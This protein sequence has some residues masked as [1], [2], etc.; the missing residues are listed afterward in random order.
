MVAEPAA[1]PIV[2]VGRRKMA[3]PAIRLRG[4]PVRVVT[5]KCRRHTVGWSTDMAYAAVGIDPQGQM[6]VVAVPIQRIAPGR[7]VTHWLFRAVARVADIKRVTDETPG[8]V[9]TREKTMP[10]APP[11]LVV[12]SRAF[13]QMAVVARSL[14]MAECTAIHRRVTRGRSPTR[15]V[16]NNPE[17]DV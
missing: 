7:R 4:E 3:G 5:G 17:I 12:R 11:V 14:G 10:A 2:R 8:S 15:A 1:V 16:R 13:V 9:D 6:T